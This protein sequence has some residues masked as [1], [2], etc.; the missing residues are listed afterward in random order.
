MESIRY[1]PYYA[2]LVA[3]VVFLG[4]GWQVDSWWY[5]PLLV[6]GPL[7]V[8]GTWNLFQ[9]KHALMRN[10]PL[11]ALIR[12]ISERVRPELRQYFFE[13][14][15]SGRPFSR[16]QRTLVYERAKNIEAKLP[17]GTELDVY[18]IDYRWANHSVMPTHIK[19]EDMRVTIGGP[20]CSQP[21]E[22]SLFNI[23]AMSFGALSAN[24]I[25]ALNAGAAKGGFA[26]DTGEGGISRY[27]REFGGD[28][29]LEVGT[30][31]F[32]CRNDKGDFCPDAFTRTAADPQVKMIELKLSQGAKPGHGGVLPAAKVTPEIAEA[33]GV[34]VG[35]DC[36]SPPAHSTFS[37]PIEMMQFIKQLR[38]LS[39][40]KP[41]G[42][43]LCVGHRWEFMAICKAMIETGIKPDFIVVDGAEGGTGAAPIEYSDS[44]GTP[45]R[46]GLNFVQNVLVGANLRDGIKL[47]ASGKI[48]SA[49]DM[50]AMMS[51]GA[52]WCNSARGFMFA[53][54]CVQ[55]QSCHTNRCPVGV[56]TQDTRRQKAIDH[57]DKSERVYHFHK[58]TIKALAE[59]VSSIGLAKPADLRP[60]HIYLRE[61]TRS[62][63]SADKALTWLE[64]GALFGDNSYSGYTEY[65]AAAD[66]TRFDPQG[67]GLTPIQFRK[68]RW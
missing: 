35:V 3:S 49:F 41:V 30:G 37:T 61:G 24:A 58:S 25:R 56:A 4:L 51:L 39:G 12:F 14:N 34:P 60:R 10:Y 21:Y 2:T 15:L 7:A 19:P 45:L 47:G 8:I 55:S 64:P 31:Y 44:L 57:G 32:G 66:P 13:S 1:F 18:D 33:R 5:W 65:W 46:Q 27:H 53:L 23:S 6:T 52:D 59:F 28:I 26:H 36:I 29:I 48:V 20:E 22:A 40:G 68:E 67:E 63:L 42:F 50:A 16:E 62:V 43:K 17:F 54:G 38:D 9:P 11:T